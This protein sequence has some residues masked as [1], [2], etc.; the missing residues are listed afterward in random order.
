MGVR[1]ICLL[2][3][4]GTCTAMRSQG[5]SVDE[6]Y[7][8][9]AANAERSALGLGVLRWDD[10]L[11]R[12]AYG[13]AVQMAKYSTISHQFA[14]EPELAS[15]G[16]SVGATFSRLSE[17]VAE[18]A[19]AV[20]I[21]EA[22]MRSPGH[23]ENLLDPQLDAVGISVQQR[24]GQLY[25]VED[26]ERSVMTLSLQEQEHAVA[27]IIVSAGAVELLLGSD[28][29]RR[30]CAMS[31]G[32]AGEQRPAFVMRFTSGD[33]GSIPQGLKVKLASGRYR[34]AAVAACATAAGNPFTSYRIAVLL[35]P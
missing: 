7:L 26:F 30:T 3:A 20:R 1:F 24:N 21:H 10:G 33:G 11:H 15:R 31:T 5:V 35:Y 6:R 13:H 34:Q 4:L 17:N 9:Q 16:H 18:A 8:F 25:A 27:Q 23:R 29:A 14:G 28:D 12:A 19:T 22:W 2:L 32:Y